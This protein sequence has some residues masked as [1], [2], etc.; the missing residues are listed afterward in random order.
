MIDKFMSFVSF[1]RL[2]KQDVATSLMFLLIIGIGYTVFESRKLIIESYTEHS[3]S[4]QQFERI[5][6]SNKKVNITL[7]RLVA[8][9]GADAALISR[10]HNGKEDLTGI[11][12]HFITTEFEA[13]SSNFVARNGYTVVYPIETDSHLASIDKTLESVFPRNADPVCIMTDSQK[14]KSPS[15]RKRNIQ[16]GFTRGIICPITNINEYPIG[17]LSLRFINK[18]NENQVG[19]FVEKANATA[20]KVGGYLDS[21]M[22]VQ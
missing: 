11:P 7:E 6:E 14:V 20:I 22:K 17:L 21:K 13:I 8:E 9:T 18:P 1:V 5:I 2:H 15:F 3:V 16:L 12:F 19:S 4:G 10:F